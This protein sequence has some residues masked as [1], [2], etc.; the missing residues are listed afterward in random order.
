MGLDL[1]RIEAWTR[2]MLEGEARRRGIRSPEFRTRGDLMRL[3]LRH[4]YGDRLSAGR[5]RIAQGRRGLAQAREL[6]GMAVGAALSSLPEPFGA[7]MR[8]RSRLPL[9]SPPPA[10]PAAK[11]PEP[12]AKTVRVE[13]EPKAA[14]PQPRN[15]IV[16]PAA[17]TRSEVVPAIAAEPPESPA[18]PPSPRSEPTTRTFIE[19]PIRTRSM[20]RLLAAQGHR[21]R[22]LVIYEELLGRNSEDRALADEAAAVRRGEPV[23]APGL[24]EPP[25]DLERVS[26]PAIGDRLQCEGE[27]EAGLLL[28][29]NITEAGQRRA[30][31][32]LGRD[33]ELT[34]RV[35][36]IRPDPERVVRSEV[37]E[38][39]PVEPS[40]QWQTPALPA[41]VRCFAAVGLREGERFVAIVHVHPGAR[42]QQSVP[43]ERAAASA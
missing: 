15:E 32:V 2:D 26:M 19:E 31:A 17:P 18:S 37:T 10:R 16:P 12:R 43:P 29:W 35:I 42:H 23:E 20:A 9:Q 27:P 5:D 11:R 22:A 33:G 8:L 1:S 7:L 4:Q 25:P 30:R 3:I 21:E 36:C 41:T 6:V 13:P 28:R 40:G 14:P 39:G 24:P 34:I 38:H